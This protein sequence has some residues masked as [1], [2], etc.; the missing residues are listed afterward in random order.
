MSER[1]DAQDLLQ[2]ARDELMQLLLPALPA[3]LRY[4]AL[5]IANAMAI[6]A[7]ES[8]SGHAAGMQELAGLCQL[9]QED[10]GLQLHDQSLQQ[11]LQQLRKRLAGQIR[12]G[13]FDPPGDR[14]AA[15][16]L[17]LAGTVK[18]KVAISNPKA[19]SKKLAA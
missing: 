17:H 14:H 16:M 12:Q 11:A 19:L 13:R 10:A 18:A 7:R 4:Q 3:S 5:M 8:A 9:L 15:L 6:A 2:V 1:P